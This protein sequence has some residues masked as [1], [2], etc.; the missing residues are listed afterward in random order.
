MG[1]YS[2]PYF[3]LKNMKNEIF[4]DLINKE[5]E[6]YNITVNDIK[7]DKD[8]FEKYTFDSFEE[9][10]NWRDYCIETIRKRCKMSKRKAEKEFIMFSLCYGLKNNFNR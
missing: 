10:N 3:F 5:L 9:Y 7:E 8:W 1:N 4:E 2:L 6:K